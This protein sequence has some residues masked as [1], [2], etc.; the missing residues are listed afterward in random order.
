M[1]LWYDE[2][3]NELVSESGTQTFRL[4]LKKHEQLELERIVDEHIR[5]D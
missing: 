4:E 5:E 3:T 1:T 2:E